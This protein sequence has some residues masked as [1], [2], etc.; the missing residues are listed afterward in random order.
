MLDGNLNIDNRQAGRL[1]LRGIFIGTA[2]FAA[3]L[4]TVYGILVMATLP[5]RP[6]HPTELMAVGLACA[7]PLALMVAGA[8]FPYWKTAVCLAVLGTAL[9]TYGPVVIGGMLFYGVGAIALGN[10]IYRLRLDSTESALLAFVLGFGT[11][12]VAIGFTAP[13]RIHFDF[14][15]GALLLSAILLARKQLIACARASLALLVER[16]RLSSTGDLISRLAVTTAVFVAL[17]LMLY[18]SARETGFDALTTHFYMIDH[19]KTNGRFVFDIEMSPFVL[20]P[21][22]SI[23]SLSVGHILGGEF[24]LRALHASLF[25]VTAG[26]IAGRTA[27]QMGM[28]PSALMIAGFLSAPVVYWVS[29][30]LFEESGTTLFLTGAAVFFLRGSDTGKPLQMDALALA[31]LGLA[32]SSKPQALFFGTLGVVIVLRRLILSGFSPAS[33]PGLAGGCVLFL[34]LAC[35]PY[36]RAFLR[37]GNPFHPFTPGSTV[38]ARWEHPVTLQTPYDMVFNTSLHM[39]AWPGGFAFQFL[40]LLA[41]GLLV[42]LTGRWRSVSSLAVVALVFCAVL[43]LQTVYARYQ[44]YTFPLLMISLAALYP[45]LASWVRIG[46]GVFLFALVPLNLSFWQSVHVPT[47]QLRQLLDPAQSPDV[48]GERRVF[49]F[50]NAAYGSEATV[51]IAG[52]PRYAGGLDGVAHASSR[53][54]LEMNKAETLSGLAD[55]L[56]RGQITHVVLGGQPSNPLITELCRAACIPLPDI[57]PGIQV[58]IVNPSRVS[59]IAERLDAF[60]LLG[61]PAPALPAETQSP[62]GPLEMLEG[63]SEEPWGWWSTGP[64]S[65]V[66]LGEAFHGARRLAFNIRPFRPPGA[67]ALSVNVYIDDALVDSWT[68]ENVPVGDSEVRVLELSEPVSAEA[69]NLLRLSYSSTLSPEEILGNGDTRE[70]AL[71]INSIEAQPDGE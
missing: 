70:I 53:L 2:L 15:Y 25:L 55:G 51:Y 49:D 38:D 40:L 19:L 34:V 67:P 10:L 11:L 7:L 22:T 46:L 58:F 57:Q 37:A 31:C 68:F 61:L 26:L 41:A 24:A 35:G 64:E 17:L 6:W 52:S 8:F 63:W 56:R 27:P 62:A 45:L 3:A 20:M 69:P 65:T 59:L 1:S 32:V 18:A 29:S 5:A 33:L 4:V 47:F 14:V 39:E 12:G 50:L 28:G 43:A 30:Q 16:A 71:G 36:L 21:K 60:E 9:V 44:L 42:L 48:P 54:A 13:L 23:W 66:Q